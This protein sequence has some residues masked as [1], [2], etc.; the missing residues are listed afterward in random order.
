MPTLKWES[1]HCVM[2]LYHCPF[3]EIPTIVAVAFAGGQ[4]SQLNGTKIRVN[5]MEQPCF[6]V[7]KLASS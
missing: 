5:K 3:L 1:T 4:K 7:T 6:S 2:S